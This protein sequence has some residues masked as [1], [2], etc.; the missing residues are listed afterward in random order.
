MSTLTRGP[1]LST[2]TRRPPD[3][4]RCRVLLS[5][6]AERGQKTN[7]ASCPR[8]AARCRHVNHA[9]RIAMPSA[10]QAGQPVRRVVMSPLSRPARHPRSDPERLSNDPPF[11][12]T[13]FQ[14][15]SPKIGRDAASAPVRESASPDTRTVSA[16]NTPPKRPESCPAV[17]AVDFCRNPD[18]GSVGRRP[19]CQIRAL[20]LSLQGTPRNAPACC[21]Q[22]FQLPCRQRST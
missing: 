8:E 17:P 3:P 21:P 1:S 9:A 19:L 7:S 16:V 4:A 13:P 11:H 20:F 6:R 15:R 14:R 5:S 12:G 18:T 10:L 22:T 2:P